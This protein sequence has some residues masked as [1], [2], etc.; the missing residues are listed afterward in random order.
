MVKSRDKELMKSYMDY[1]NC[2]IWK[3]KKQNS[4]WIDYMV[5][6]YDDQVL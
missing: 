6:R 5:V 4:T 2:Y 1:L 3:K